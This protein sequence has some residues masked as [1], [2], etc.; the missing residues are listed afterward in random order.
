MVEMGLPA[1]NIG[2]LDSTTARPK[3]RC[4][5]R[6]HPFKV[7]IA[8]SGCG[9]DCSYSR[10][11]KPEFNDFVRQVEPHLESIEEPGLSKNGCNDSRS[12]PR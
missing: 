9:F 4:L 5:R 3:E 10:S 12:T 1:V 2:S 6:S 11:I 8:A 7:T